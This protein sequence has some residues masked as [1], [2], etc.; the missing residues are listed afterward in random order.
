[1]ETDGPD[2]TGTLAYRRMAGTHRTLCPRPNKTRRYG[3]KHDPHNYW[4]PYQHEPE[5]KLKKNLASD[6]LIEAQGKNQ[7]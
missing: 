4:T 3:Y 5:L 6:S 7:E 1:M 2:H